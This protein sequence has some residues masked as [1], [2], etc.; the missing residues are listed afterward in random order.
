MH[1]KQG[2]CP[3]ESCDPS[4][5]RNIGKQWGT[6]DCLVSQLQV[7]LS[8][9]FSSS[10][11][12]LEDHLFVKMEING[13]LLP[14]WRKAVQDWATWITSSSWRRCPGCLQPSLSAT[15]L[16][17]T[18][19]STSWCVTPTANKRRSTCLRSGSR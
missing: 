1:Y 19:A 17:P 10:L 2:L 16:T 14:Q 6:W 7:G 9:F 4:L 15:A 13:V 5:C 18:C 12:D 3:S 8:F 11:I